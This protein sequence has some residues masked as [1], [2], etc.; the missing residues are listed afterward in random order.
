[1]ASSAP[2]DDASIAKFNAEYD[3]SHEATALR[4]R[5]IFIREF[6]LQ[7]LSKMTLDKY[8]IGQQNYT[9]FC[10]LV[11][12]GSRAWANIQGATARKFGVY[13]G[14]TKSDP[15]RKYRFGDRFGT[16]EKEAFATV[17]SALLEL[18]A[19]G[20][21]D[22]PDFKAI[23]A[24]PLSQMFK[25]KILSLYYPDRFLA[26]CSA[27]HL[28]QIAG[29]LGLDSDLPSSQYQ[30][31][32]L[33]VKRGNPLARKW[34]APKFMVYLYETYM[35]V[36]RPIESPI[37]KPSA[38]RHKR[39]DF[40]EMQKQRAEIGRKAEEYALE[41]E[42]ERLAGAGLEHLI[43]KI[44]DRRSRPSFGHDFLSW[45]GKDEP[46]YIE[47]KC[48]AK[49]ADGHRFFLSE[50]EHE[51]SR[52]KEHCA[53]Y[54]FCLVFF[55]GGGQP[56]ELLAVLAGQLYPHAELTPSSYEVRFDR[57]KFDS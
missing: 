49:Q 50:N 6:P 27:E 39:V 30:N 34:S 17:K 7:S 52:S 32:L 47:V 20:A 37:E 2:L 35:D 53:G 25:A 41:W 16:N 51:I 40:E 11:E 24:N 28:E 18:V 46:R 5:G 57:K 38:K 13:Y 8:V 56:S 43:S 19:L 9:S 33:K 12:A 14:R 45:N 15:T 55:D 4:T 22:R 31:L 29:D 48:V 23:D 21:E 26:V 10:Y 42:K 54:Y 36:D 1:M 44:D 3:T